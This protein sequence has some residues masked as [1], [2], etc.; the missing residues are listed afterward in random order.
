MRAPFYEF[1]VDHNVSPSG[2]L[3]FVE[4]K[5]EWAN[6]TVWFIKFCTL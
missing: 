2:R 1:R 3:G 4:E 5:H 6:L